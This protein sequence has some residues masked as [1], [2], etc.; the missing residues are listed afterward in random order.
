M[1]SGNYSGVFVQIAKIVLEDAVG[2][3]DREHEA[4]MRW[5]FGKRRLRR[6][7][8]EAAEE[9]AVNES[10]ETIWGDG[11]VGG[12]ER[13]YPAHS[14]RD[15]LV[16]L[17]EMG[18]YWPQREEDRETARREAR[19]Y[20]PRREELAGPMVQERVYPWLAAQK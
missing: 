19:G 3:R 4:A 11:Q 17:G 15:I 14:G 7:R 12:E 5:F 2:R 10:G 13:F 16:D 9:R 8:E 20:R 18:L 1:T 6:N